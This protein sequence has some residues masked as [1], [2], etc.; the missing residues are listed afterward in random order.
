M[1]IESAVEGLNDREDEVVR[2]GGRS[3]GA[4]ASGGRRKRRLKGVVLSCPR[5]AALSKP[6][7]VGVRRGLLKGLGGFPRDPSFF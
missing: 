2:A 5:R 6:G 1:G 7:Y 3:V 4:Y